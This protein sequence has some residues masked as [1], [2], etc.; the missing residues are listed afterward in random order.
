MV[1][2]DFQRMTGFSI[3]MDLKKHRGQIFM[4]MS[5]AVDRLIPVAAVCQNMIT[6]LKVLVVMI[7]LFKVWTIVSPEKQPP[8]SGVGLSVGDG[9]E[10]SSFKLSKIYPEN[11][12]LTLVVHALNVCVE[13]QP[14][15]S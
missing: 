14:Q 1:A 3:C 4:V 12:T 7:P 6:N 5:K 13:P 15:V 10:Q 11:H 2:S 9:Q 8:P